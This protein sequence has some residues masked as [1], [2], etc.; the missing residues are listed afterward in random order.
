MPP[1]KWRWEKACLNIISG[2]TATDAFIDAGFSPTSATNHTTR[3]LKMDKIKARLAELQD[4]TRTPMVMS[5]SERKERLSEIGRADVTDFQTKQGIQVDKNMPNT[6]A[7]ESLEVIERYSRD[8]H[9]GS[10]TVKRAVVPE[11]LRNKIFKRDE[12]KCVDC[13]STANLQIDHIIPLSKGGKT[14]KS[15][16]QT[17]CELCNKTKGASK[18]SQP[19]VITKL[20]LHSPIQ[21]IDLLNKM[22]KVYSD[23]PLVNIDNRQVNIYVSS[24]KAKELTEH[25]DRRLLNAI[26]RQIEETASVEGKSEET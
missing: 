12:N 22:D 3:W 7:I 25:A 5:I 4:E 19:D 16:L 15:N 14:I 1:L 21:A 10:I 6:G 17:L 20:K 24:E 11:S 9:A 2:M 13:G 8:S 26:Q 23:V 18:K